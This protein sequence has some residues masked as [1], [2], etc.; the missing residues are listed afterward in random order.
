[1]TAKPKLKRVKKK[2]QVKVGNAQYV[3]QATGEL[4]N[5]TVISKNVESDFNF[6]KVWINDL[7]AILGLIGGQKIKVFEYL[8]SI[9]RNEDNTITARYND[10][11][12][13][14]GVSR[15]TVFKTLKILKEANILRNITNTTY[16]VNPDIIVK[17]S[18]D[19]RKKLLIEYNSN[20][21]AQEV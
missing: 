9:M 10:I 11:M 19:K 1:M 13:A 12:K 3:N 2:T 17:G 7:M 16:Q 4:E 18:G 21:D 15:D 14:T 5:F 6:H 8:L 20:L